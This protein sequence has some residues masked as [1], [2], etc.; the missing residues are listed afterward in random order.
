MCVCLEYQ[1]YE[2]RCFLYIKVSFT[3]LRNKT[4]VLITYSQEENIHD[5]RA[6]YFWSSEV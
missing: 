6:D 4:A 1:F 3:S 5:L 2:Q